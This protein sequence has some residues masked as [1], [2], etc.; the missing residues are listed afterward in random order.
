MEIGAKL[1]VTTRSQWRSWLRKHHASANEI[2]LVYYK[3]GSGKARIPYDHAVEEALC[4]GWI[5]SIVKPIDEKRYTQRFSPRRPGSFLSELNKERVRRL[6]AS[7]KMTKAGL[8]KIRHHLKA[9]AGRPAAAGF[10]PYVF[11]PDILGEIRKS[12][13]AWKAFSKFP[14]SYK[15]VRIGWIDAARRRPKIFRQRLRY[16]I[17]MTVRNRRFGM[18]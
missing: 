7:R 18:T 12:A 13:E 4:Y 17:R 16:F 5:D 15:R 14:V 3:K 2:W 8:E 11:P 10:K 9:P 6:V 1:Y